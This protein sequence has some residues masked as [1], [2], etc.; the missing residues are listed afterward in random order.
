MPRARVATIA[1]SLVLSSLDLRLV[2]NVLHRSAT[3]TLRS[4]DRLARMDPT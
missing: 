2:E 1:S 4:R 3:Y